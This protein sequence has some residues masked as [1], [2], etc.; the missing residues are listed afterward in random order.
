MEI[1]KLEHRIAKDTK[2]L[3]TMKEHLIRHR[4]GFFDRKDEEETV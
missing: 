3:R 2:E 4:R 1:A